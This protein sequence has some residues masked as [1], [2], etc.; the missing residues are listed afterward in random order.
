MLGVA[1]CKII[2]TFAALFGRNAA[3][4]FKTMN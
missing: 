3:E 4:F 2:F 1:D